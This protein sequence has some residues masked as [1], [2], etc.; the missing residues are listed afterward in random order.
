MS[1]ININENNKYNELI[2]TAN[3]DVTD[4]N[5]LRE[6]FENEV[7]PLY[8]SKDY[9]CLILILPVSMVSCYS[10]LS[11]YE[12]KYTIDV[13]KV[14]N[15]R[16]IQFNKINQVVEIPPMATSIIKVYSWVLFRVK[17]RNFFDFY[18]CYAQ[19]EDFPLPFGGFV[20]QDGDMY[21]SMFREISEES[22]FILNDKEYCILLDRKKNKW[23]FHI[24]TS[25]YYPSFR[26]NVDM[27]NLSG[28]LM[29]E[30]DKIPFVGSIKSKSD[31]IDSINCKS[32]KDCIDSFPDYIRYHIQNF[33]RTKG[34]KKL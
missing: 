23:M 16:N 18:L 11:N 32:L 7:L 25:R 5:L 17:N 8:E 24:V 27:V 9:S 10:F 2:V 6:S 1:L 34:T 12:N 4:A 19:R 31:Q 26:Y 33:V 14:K 28:I 13:T 29:V 20:D 15:K 21:D 22:E 3:E 30:V